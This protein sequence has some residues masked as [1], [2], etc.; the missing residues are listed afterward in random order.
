MR[1]IVLQLICL[2]KNHKWLGEWKHHFNAQTIDKEYVGM[3]RWCERCKKYIG[4]N[5]SLIGKI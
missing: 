3:F 1:A 4:I 2:F 5:E